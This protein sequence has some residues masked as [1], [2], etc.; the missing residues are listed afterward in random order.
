MSKDAAPGRLSAV[1]RVLVV[2]AI[3]V[4]GGILGQES[5][6]MSGSVSLVW[7]PAGIALAAILLFGNAFWPGVAFG[8]V[9]FGV[10]TGH[11]FGFFTLGTAV[12]NTVGALVCAYLLDRFVQFQRPLERVRDVVGFI[13]LACL[14]GTTVNATFNV[15]GLIYSGAG[16]WNDLASKLLDWW[17]PNAMSCLVVTPFVLAWGSRSSIEW[18]TPLIVEASLCAAGLIGGTFLSFHSWLIYG[19]QNY[20]FAYLPY[21]FLVWGALRFG[22]AGAATGTLLVT[23]AAIYN[24]LQ[25]RGPFVAHT[26]KESLTLIG[27]YIGILA[28]TNLFLAAAAAERRRAEA[29]ARKSE[30]MFRL[31]SENVTD[32]IAVT[33]A[34]GTR[35]YNSPSYQTILG[36]PEQLVGTEAF[37][38]IHPDDREQV[39][40]VFA[41]T[42]KTGRGRQI[43]F[44]FLLPGGSIRYIESQ[45]NYVAGGAGNQGKVVSVARDITRRKEADQAL[46]ESEERFRLLVE[47]VRDYAICMLD[48]KGRVASWNTGAEQMTGYRSDEII[49]R[50]YS[51]LFGADDIRA[52]KP[53]ALLRQ[54]WTEG[55]TEE[56]G[57]RIKKD[58]SLFW[59][60]A[61]MSALFDEAGGLRG[62]VK[63]TRDVT[64]RRE[65]EQQLARAH[66]AA[67][68][69]ARLK[70]EFLANMSH[71]I[72]TPLNGVIGMT[73]LLLHTDLN[74]L[75]RDYTATI[76]RS[77][78]SLLLIINDI[79]DFSKIEAG[80][81]QIES[82]DFDLEE[83][84]GDVVELLASDAHAKRIELVEVIEP[85]VPTLLRGDPVRIR[86]VLLNLVG[87]AVK[88]TERGEVVVR[89]STNSESAADAV[90]RFEVKDTGIGIAEEVQSRLFEPF[91]QADGSMTRRYGGS[92]LGLAISKQLV[93]L[94]HGHINMESRLGA[95]STFWFQLNLSKQTDTAFHE[96]R[97]QLAGLRML[98]VDDNAAQRQAI[99]GQLLAWKVRVEVAGGGGEAFHKLRNAPPEDRFAIVLL[100]GEI[101]DVSS[102]ALA[103]QIKSDA[104]LAG[105]RIVLMMPRGG[106]PQT[107]LDDHTV[108]DDS[109]FKPVKQ[110][111]LAECLI[112]LVTGAQAPSHQPIV[113][114]PNGNGVRHKLR[115]LVVEDSVINQKVALGQLD[116]LGYAAD[117][118]A[119]GVE[120][121]KAVEQS[122]YDVI[123]MD[124][125]MPEMDGYE[126]TRLIRER[127]QRRQHRSHI[128]AMTAHAMRGDRERCLAAGMDEYI[129]KPV[130]QDDLQ[131][132]LDRCRPA[133]APQRPAVAEETPNQTEPPVNFQRLKMITRRDPVRLREIVDLY[134]KSAEDLVMALACAALTRSAPDIAQAAH[135][136]AGSSSSCGMPRIASTLRDLE[137]CATNEDWTAIPALVGQAQTELAQIREYLR[138]SGFV[139]VE[140][141]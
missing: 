112:A 134:L 59:A 15:V 91:S 28:V 72:R 138:A 29:A 140:T 93:E 60:N 10:M 129:S 63:I 68:E 111:R 125:Q 88:F 139:T 50:H 18:T 121:L 98:V 130:E 62:F 74:A 38:E 101:P 87:N 35:L 132:V 105:T 81:L 49:G 1:T 116:L 103:A 6:F 86:Q 92:G 73:N 70:A 8:A 47:G 117:I 13:V 55:F 109:L 82:T 24:H 114:L 16:S 37:N 40:A 42:I 79:L 89:V 75:Q 4:L 43:E 2:S 95:G 107:E 113:K 54:A 124:C 136:L 119:N 20:P 94:M 123:L 127:E 69:S 110:S 19:L 137:Q 51:C 23:S 21:P 133:D 106:R 34:D 30:Q 3:Y 122:D 31:I 90:I 33:G 12:G 32:L 7:P 108:V 77:A 61:V 96:T 120:A 80:K 66:H 67:L 64:R 102:V 14:L 36:S 118:A 17:V 46:R 22:P 39:K 58:G 65:V 99:S 115:I 57:P 71:E 100:D 104:F 83:V 85:D 78:D 11:P 5:S 41:D 141:V 56:E 131:A 25:G 9:I 26:E 76:Q 97:R 128:V 126:A 135:K 48:P 45:G 44:R 84:V 52:A 53:D 27:T